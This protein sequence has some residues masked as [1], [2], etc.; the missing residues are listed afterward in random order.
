MIPPCVLLLAPD[1]PFLGFLTFEHVQ[2]Q[3]SQGGEVF[4]GK[5]RTSPTLIFPEADIHMPVDGVFHPPMRSHGASKAKDILRQTGEIIPSF[6]CDLAVDVAHRLHHSDTPQALPLTPIGE[7]V[8]SLALPVSAG[9]D[10]AMVFLDSL[11]ECQ[12]KGSPV[13]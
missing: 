7:P 6:G 13:A 3:A 10:A 12:R 1:A 8:Q 2:G 5:S 11:V 9:L 4:C